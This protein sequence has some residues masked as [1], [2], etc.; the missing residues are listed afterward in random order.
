MTL[1]ASGDFQVGADGSIHI[2]PELVPGPAFTTMLAVLGID[3][4]TLSGARVLPADDGSGDFSVTGSTEILDAQATDVSLYLVAEEG[5][6]GYGFQLT[7]TLGSLR[8]RTLVRRGIIPPDR[9][10]EVRP[11]LDLVFTGVDLIFD[12]DRETLFLGVPASEHDLPLLAQLGLPL[13]GVGFEFARHYED[14]AA[15]LLLRPSIVF[16]AT[17]LEPLVSLPVGPQAP[18]AWTVSLPSQVRLNQG[19]TD[20]VAFVAGTDAGR[21]LGVDDWAGQFPARLH[22]IPALYLSGLEINVDPVA[23]RLVTLAFTLESAHPLT[24]DGTTFTVDRLGASVALFLWE[25]GPHML[26]TLFGH[27]MLNEYAALGLSIDIPVAGRAGPWRVA[28]NASVEVEDLNHLDNLP[29]NTGVDEFHLPS[30]FFQMEALDLRRFE[31]VFEPSRGIET[32][33]LDLATRMALRLGSALAVED[34]AITLR[35]INPFK[36]AGIGTPRSITGSIRGVVVIGEIAFDVEAE[37]RENGWSFSGELGGLMRIGVALDSVSRHFGLTLPDALRDME[38]TRLGLR[39]AT[40]AAPPPQHAAPPA[41]AP[42]LEH[43]APAAASPAPEGAPTPAGKNVSAATKPPLPASAAQTAPAATAAAPPATR[44]TSTDVAFTCAG[45]LPVGGGE[46]AFTVDIEVS[47]QAD[48][49]YDRKVQGTLSFAGMTFGAAF[50]ASELAS[51]FVATYQ[52][53]PDDPGVGLGELARALAPEDPGLPPELD[54]VRLSLRDALFAYH[55][56]KLPGGGAAPAKT[57]VAL[58]AGIDVGL[59]ALPLAGAALSP[60]QKPRLEFQPL[61]ATDDLTA[62]DL[63]AMSA[64]AQGGGPALPDTLPRG[65]TLALTLHLGGTPLRLSLPV[66]SSRRKETLADGSAG[67][68]QPAPPTAAAGTPAATSA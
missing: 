32:V 61:Y 11:V 55:R 40:T 14:G 15:V 31:V 35:V 30:G 37:K 28:L 3:A 20:L 66:G 51:S 6:P 42:T 18:R 17:R 22:A 27:V 63:A 58:D 16:G 12:S 54:A 1:L 26:L 46:L 53:S 43:A 24:L 67:T 34:P 2:G 36:S 64:L 23:P 47:E 13:E 59:S 68:A 10:E 19:L 25:G 39:F 41:A 29:I 38:L 48:G 44:G 8:L 49:G 62:E 50:G 7:A 52:A 65:L 60:S 56:P 9:H 33:D 45:T 4:L 57:L 21:A 5:G